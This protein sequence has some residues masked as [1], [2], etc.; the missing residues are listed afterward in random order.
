MLSKLGKEIQDD[1]CE[2]DKTGTMTLSIRTTDVQV[3]L[4]I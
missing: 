2:R 4:N 1:F 3:T